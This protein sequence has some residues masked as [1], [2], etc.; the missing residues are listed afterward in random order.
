MPDN[1]LQ[2]SNAP[3]T[4]RT[5]LHLA[6]FAGAAGVAR[7]LNAT[8]APAYPPVWQITRGPKHH[9]FGYYD[10]LEFDPTNR[11]VLS[12]EVDFEHRS[13]RADDV[14]GVGMVDTGD[15]DRWIPIGQSN[16]WGWQQGCMLQWRPGSAT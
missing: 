11:Y 1:P 3:L 5:F 16:A 12:N 14:I 10:K 8:D 15:K 6:A 7:P 2:L 9:W 13:P 4:R